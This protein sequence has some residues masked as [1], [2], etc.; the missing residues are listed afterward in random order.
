MRINYFDV[1]IHKGEEI[2]MFQ[3]AVKPLGAELH[4]YGFE[5]Y[6]PLAEEAEERF[7]DD[8]NI[9]IINK[10]ISDKSGY[11]HLYL[12]KENDFEGNSIFETKN[13]V[14]PEDHVLVKC[15]KFT[16]WLEET[17]PDYKDHINVVRFNIE[18]AETHLMFDIIDSMTHRYIKLFL[19]VEDGRDI[20]KCEELVN[21][22]YFYMNM[23]KTNRIKIYPYCVA[24][25]DNIAAEK[26]R[27]L[28]KK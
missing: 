13:N 8:E 22:H 18:G 16:E 2:V 24:R 1:G 7:K 6:L 11:V 28:L 19:G 27:E 25:K 3:E 15:V 9:T 23:I 14:D 21:L 12:A 17:I 20:L 10:A 5:A 4:I 26:I